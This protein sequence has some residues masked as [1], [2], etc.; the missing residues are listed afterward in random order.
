MPASTRLRDADGK[1]Q[2]RNVICG[3]TED[4]IGWH[5]RRCAAEIN[6]GRAKQLDAAE[7]GLRV[8][9]TNV[10]GFQSDAETPIA[11]R[12]QGKITDNL[13]GTNPQITDVIAQNLPVGKG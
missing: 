6:G 2:I 11:A 10:S 13:L 4:K 7:I 5:D 3:V 12:T 8:K 1:K 9:I